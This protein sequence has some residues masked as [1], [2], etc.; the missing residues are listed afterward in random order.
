MH[1]DEDYYLTS[2]WLDAALRPTGP[3]PNIA[4]DGEQGSGKS[5]ACRILRRLV[6]PNAADLRALARGEDDLLIAAVNSRVIGIDNV[7]FIEADM[8]DALCRVATGAGFSKRTLYSNQAETIVSVCRPILLNGIPATTAT[9]GDLADRSSALTLPTI[10]E[11]K[12][13]TEVEVWA[14]FEA[15]APGIF[16][17]LLDGL[18]MA[19]KRLPTVQLDQLPRMADFAK[20]ACAAAPAFGW[21]EADMIAAMKNNRHKGTES[22]VE[23]DPIASAI[24]QIASES[25]NGWSGTATELLE[26]IETLTPDAVTRERGW[27]KDTARLSNRVTRAAPALRQVGVSVEL[28]RQG[29]TGKKI[30]KI[31]EME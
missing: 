24:R 17:L 11:D 7:S 20:V 2:A 27:P 21:T 4:V 1:S 25:K 14:E 18:V 6:D 22:V 29:G 12:R 8:A 10:P 3:Y 5:T 31:K 19:L 26:E 30:W 13:R 16:A 28:T 15:A 9:R 23:G